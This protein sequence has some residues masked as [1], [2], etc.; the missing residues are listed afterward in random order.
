MIHIL[1][2]RFTPSTELHVKAVLYPFVTK[3]NVT[4]LKIHDFSS[5][6]DKLKGCFN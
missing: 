4:V 3:V 6:F 5:E 2:S 1:L